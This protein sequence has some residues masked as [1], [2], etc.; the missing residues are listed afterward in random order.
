[1]VSAAI[2]AAVALGGCDPEQ[3]KL[4]KS[5][6]PLS[7]QMLA[8]IERKNMAKDSQIVVR[9]FK[10]EAEL[11]VWKQ[12]HGGRFQLLKTYPIC[13]WSGELGPKVKEGDR[14]APEGFYTI[15]QANLNPNSAYYLSI[16]IGYP[17]DYDRAWGH[18]GS[19]LMIHGDCS[20]RG[21]YAMTNEQIE[22]IYGLARDSFLGGQ[23]AFQIQAYPFRMTALNMAKHR[24]SPHM[25]FWR[26]LKQGNDHFEVSQQQPVV[27]VCEK[28]YVFNAEA[29]ANASTPLKFSPA[30]RC[31]VYTV[32][33]ELAAAVA[34]KTQRDETEFAQLSKH[35]GTVPART[36]RDGGMHPTFLARVTRQVRDADGKTRTVV[37]ENA[38]SMLGTYVNPPHEPDTPPV[39]PN[40]V[41]AN[42]AANPVGANAAG[43][44]AVAASVP[45][46]RR[47]PW[48]ARPGAPADT[49]GTPSSVMS[50]A[51]ADSRP[52][53]PPE[54]QNPIS[55]VGSTVAK[56]IGLGGDDKKPATTPPKPKPANAV[57]RRPALAAKPANVAAAPSQ[58]KPQTV[59][60]PGS[61]VRTSNASAPNLL[62]GAQPV[63]PGDTFE[64]R[65]T[66]AR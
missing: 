13:R 43:G 63:V 48:A 20:S 52:P 55:R 47:A 21:C 9:V 51:A 25:S 1:M 18:T 39:Q 34:D 16:N 36:G 6:K 64:S 8:L 66:P 62:S 58:P 35:T 22:E 37:D 7:A 3:L 10:E 4:A 32:N 30:G 31:P 59:P 5:M 15:T 49:G 26:M 23:R 60:P 38:A 50:L 65:W 14:Q 19:A 33:Q 45:M 41:A 44:G 2:A 61:E 54:Q 40:A 53:A 29:P 28:R 57:A 46:P 24:N 11:E 17:N 12:D 27:S 42:S 56:W